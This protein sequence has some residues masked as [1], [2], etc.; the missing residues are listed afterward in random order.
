VL[1]FAGHGSLLKKASVQVMTKAVVVIPAGN[2]A[3]WVTQEASNVRR[4]AIGALVF[5]GESFQER[6]N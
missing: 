3:C 1:V 5:A 6:L 4:R 2:L